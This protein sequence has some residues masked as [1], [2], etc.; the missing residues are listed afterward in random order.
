[1]SA[2]RRNTNIIEIGKVTLNTSLDNLYIEHIETCTN[3]LI[4][5]Y[6]ELLDISESIS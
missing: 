6:D 2:V 4:L 1:M 3:K 5:A